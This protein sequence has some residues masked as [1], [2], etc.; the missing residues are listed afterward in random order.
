MISLCRY[1]VIIVPVAFVMAR[2]FGPT[3]V[4]NAFWITELV[5]AAVSLAV[6]RKA[7]ARKG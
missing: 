4:W 7:V 2:I 6:Y 5:T 3:G 1:L